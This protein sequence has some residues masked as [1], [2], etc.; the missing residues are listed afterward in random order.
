MQEVDYAKSIFELLSKHYEHNII[1]HW[2]YIY[3][4]GIRA[5][6]DNRMNYRVSDIQKRSCNDNCKNGRCKEYYNVIENQN[7]L[8]L[9]Y[10]YLKK[11]KFN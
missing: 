5:E 11:Q 7:I 3:Y 1:E 4:K 8:R 10:G 9:I 6:R 2:H